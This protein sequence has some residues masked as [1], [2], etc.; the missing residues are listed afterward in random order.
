MSTPN[1]PTVTTGE[2]AD[3]DWLET[4]RNHVNS[5]KFG[6]VQ[7]VVHDSV[8]VQVERTEKVRFG[9]RKLELH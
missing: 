2:L 3:A 9:K 8:V 6:V 5:I 1:T 4:V 7:I